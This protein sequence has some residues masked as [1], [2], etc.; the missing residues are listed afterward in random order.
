ME[1]SQH[2]I[3]SGY[4]ERTTARQVAAVA[5]LTGKLVVITGGYAGLGLETTRVLAERGAE[6]IA[7]ARDVAKATENLAGIPDVAVRPL[8]LSGR[9]SIDRFADA[10]V[11]SARGIDLP[12]NNAG[13]MA[14][15]L[16]RVPPG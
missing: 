5:D 7:G 4:G 3:G 10:V 6:I 11:P 12:V 13:V 14:T 15:P 2:P 8:D 16:A 1:T 9:A